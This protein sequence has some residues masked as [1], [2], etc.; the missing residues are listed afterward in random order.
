MQILSLVH[1]ED[2]GA[3]LFGP[4]VAEAGHQLDEWSF[5]W[6]TSPPQPLERYE[7]V[8]VFGGAMH[9]D[10]D[11]LHPWLQVEEDWLRGLLGRQV[12]TL[13]ICLGSELLAKA[14]GAWVGRLAAPEVGWREVALTEAGAA[15]PVLSALPA[16]FEALQWHHYGHG[17]PDGAVA[18]AENAA[19][20]QAF[21]LEDACWGVQFH[22]E[23]TEP[24][25]GRWIADEAGPPPD[26][27]RLRR[28][29]RERIGAWNQLGRRVCRSFLAA[30]ERLVARAG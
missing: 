23:V 17:L 1:G 14:A 27:E 24:Q 21:R 26:P 13:G 3:E 19:S 12:P 4:L 11:D 8:F 2:A 15:D 10:Q 16:R 5:E 6:G 25:L 18:L 20:L 7:A 9:P 29:T 28:E 22:P 30:A